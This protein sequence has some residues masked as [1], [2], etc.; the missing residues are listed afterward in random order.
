MTAPDP[1]RPAVLS[2]CKVINGREGCTCE[3][4]DGRFCEGLK[5]NI[6]GL[7]YGLGVTATQI[8]ALFDGRA[9]IRMKPRKK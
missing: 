8:E 9:T 7:F 2:L 5:P 6:R 3:K 4:T 1:M